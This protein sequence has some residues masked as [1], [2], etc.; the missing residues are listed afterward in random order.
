[1]PL[2][3]HESRALEQICHLLERDDPALARRLRSMRG[4]PTTTVLA[5]FV[6]ST[7]LIGLAAVGVGR[8]LDLSV[9][10]ASGVLFSLCGPVLGS[11]LIGR[12]RLS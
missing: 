10:T 11:V 4:G 12:L 3:D 9:L 6:L 5:L 8:G 2:N 7:A 1:M